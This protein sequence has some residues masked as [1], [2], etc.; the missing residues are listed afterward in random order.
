VVALDRFNDPAIGAMRE[1]YRVRRDFV[2]QGLRAIGCEVSEPRAGIFVWARCPI[3]PSTGQPMDSWKFVGKLIDE[4]AVVT[5][6]GAGFAESAA[7]WVRVSLTRE[8]GRIS[9]AMDRL[10]RLT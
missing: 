4:A 8:T 10:K 6:P 7:S 3:D 5:V 1:E 9:E 2:V